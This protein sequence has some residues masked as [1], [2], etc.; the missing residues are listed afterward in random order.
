[1]G[2]RLSKNL[3]STFQPPYSRHHL[4][5][6]DLVADFRDG[7][8]QQHA[9]AVDRDIAEALVFRRAGAVGGL[10]GGR[11]PALVDAAA[12]RAQ[13]VQIARIQFQPAARHQEGARHPA[14]RKS[15][16]ALA[17]RESFFD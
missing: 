10:G 13:R 3:Q 15:D 11:K 17:G 16:D 8:A 1:M 14:G 2:P 7:F 4:G 5:A 12:M 9:L 6:Q